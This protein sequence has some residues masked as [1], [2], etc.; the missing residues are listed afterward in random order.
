MKVILSDDIKDRLGTFGMFLGGIVL[1]VII[2][3][4]AYYIGDFTTG[5]IEPFNLDIFGILHEVVTI[6]VGMTVILLA[7]GLIKVSAS[8]VLY[9]KDNISIKQN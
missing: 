9:L 5:G 8:V 7:F 3:L 4:I 1:I 2:C 6:L